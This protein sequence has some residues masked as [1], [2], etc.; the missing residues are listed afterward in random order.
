MRTI[1]L[2]L[3]LAN[4]CLFIF[5]RLDSFSAGEGVRLSQ[6]VQP[7]KITLLTPQQVAALGPGKVAALADVC[8]EWG[9]F[10]D[11]ERTRALADLQPLQ[12]GALLTQRRVDVDGAFGVNVGPFA[13][14]AAA[15]KRMT[16]LRQQGA[17]DMAVVDNGRGQFNVSLGVFRT[18]Q[19]ATARAETLSKQGIRLARV[20]P[21][22]Q[23]I[24]QTMLVVRDPQQA[25]V[26]KLKD[27]Q[28]QYEGSD[29]RVGSCPTA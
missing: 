13:T 2:L 26:T 17:S 5:T 9:P 23:P 19:A 14:R 7:D 1:I 28:G 27:L 18:E 8:M 24:V 16:E 6:Q 20:E 29:L 12:L 4:L 15:E 21:R 25:I 10:S 22:A 3:L 11:A